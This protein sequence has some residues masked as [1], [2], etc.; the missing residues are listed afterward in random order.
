MADTEIKDD[1]KNRRKPTPWQ[2]VSRIG[3]VVAIG[4]VILT[5]IVYANAN[6]DA[7]QNA[8]IVEER[9]FMQIE[10]DMEAQKDKTAMQFQFVKDGM[11]DFSKALDKIDSKVDRLLRRSE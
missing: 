5:F 9:R 3:A 8:K 6:A 2:W 1:C 10:T 7:M 11:S 4:G